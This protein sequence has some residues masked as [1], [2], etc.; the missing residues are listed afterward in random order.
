MIAE[1]IRFWI[2][3]ALISIAVVIF[4][5]TFYY[6]FK[7]N[8]SKR[9]TSTTTSNSY[10]YDVDNRHEI[11]TFIDLLKDFYISDD[12]DTTIC[13]DTLTDCCYYVTDYTHIVPVYKADGTIYKLEELKPLIEVKYKTTISI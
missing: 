2:I 12:M 6:L 10:E 13:V 5:C 4:L 3:V 8:K 11:N 1:D 7:D 9:V